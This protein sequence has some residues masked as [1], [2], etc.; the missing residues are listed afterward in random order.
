MYNSCRWYLKAEQ[1]VYVY[2][3]EDE[4]NLNILI[5]IVYE[6]IVNLECL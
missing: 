6:E 4:L 1:L 5:I 2:I 3:S